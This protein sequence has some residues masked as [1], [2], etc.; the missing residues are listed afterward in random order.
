MNQEINK[1]CFDFFRMLF[2][3]NVLLAHLCEL[4]QAEELSFLSCISNSFLAVSGFFVIS[5]F[6][7]AKSYVS[8][9]S[10]K[11]YFIKR[12]KRIIPAYLFIILISA[13]LLA[14]VSTVSFS[15][16]FTSSGLYKYLGWNAIFLNFMHPCL[17]G[18]FEGNLLCAVNGALWTIK[19]EES[20]YLF[21][22]LLFFMIKKVRKPGL[23]LLA[24]YVFSFAFFTF[25]TFYL[26]KPI[27]AKQLPGMLTY[28]STGIFLFLY[29]KQVLKYRIL[30]W[31]TSIIL[32]TISYF[33]NISFLFPLAFG[34]AIILSAYSLPFLNNFGKNGDFTYGLYIFHFPIIQVFR[35]YNLFEKYNVYTM[36]LLVI[37]IS[38][39]CAL[40]SWFFIEKRFISR[41][42]KQVN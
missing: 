19:I 26:N 3:F 10:L 32:A 34:F 5:G 7:V 42:S 15:E 38:I 33:Y 13:I 27:I 28:F 39:L 11:Q 25:F 30:L 17:P 35:S 37:I 40:F 36:A 21:L 4:S 31:G 24:V 41:Y 8:T 29:F 16:Y 14:F 1:N 20:F 6:L 12:I 23:L 9:P 2:A 18:V 22:P